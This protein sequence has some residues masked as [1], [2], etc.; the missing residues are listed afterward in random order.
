MN[1]RVT[2]LMP[3]FNHERFV[4]EAIASVVA[5]DFAD[6]ELLL[7][8]DGSTDRTPQ[9]L[10][11]WAQR[12][13]RIVVVTLPGNQGIT[14]ALN[15]GLGHAR[16]PYVARLDSD[17]IMMPRRLAA[18]AAVLDAEPGVVLVSSLIEA[19]DV[20]GKYLATW[21]NDE[22]HEVMT[23]LLNFFNA[24]N[25]H[26]QVM[27]RRAEVIAAGGYPAERVVGQDYHL[28]VRLLRRGRIVTLPL[29]GMKRRLHDDRLGVRYNSRRLN[30]DEIQSESLCHYLGRP[31]R[32]EEVAAVLALWRSDV[33]VGVGA[34]A[35]AMMRE[36]YARF[37]CISSDRGQRRYVRNR[38]GS[39]WMEGARLFARAGQIAEA[40]RYVARA[41]R[42]SPAALI[43]AGSG[44]A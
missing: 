32:E 5:Q 39:K 1:P 37:C 30:K 34:T 6:F 44:S 19:I 17:D 23:F 14:A 42:W 31:V 29:V 33:S 12:D 21:R 15:V 36:A 43:G 40:V 41:A 38:I 7:V 35:D 4:D 13:A 8:D 11:A 10:Q 25:G 3:V 2:V 26:G 16:A 27:Y 18:Q 28:W 9:I 24:V 22:P 20:D